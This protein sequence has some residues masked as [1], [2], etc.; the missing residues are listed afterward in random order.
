MLT[1]VNYSNPYRYLL[2]A[3]QNEIPQSDVKKK[4]Y[5][6]YPGLEHYCELFIVLMLLGM[7]S[8][9]KLIMKAPSY[10]GH[11][12]VCYTMLS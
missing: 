5:I 11:I 4:G 2:Y 10:K 1:H 3:A 12:E 8:P 6:F 9:G 7:E